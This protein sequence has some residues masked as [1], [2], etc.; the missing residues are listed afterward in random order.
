M[1][2]LLFTRYT[3]EHTRE[4]SRTAV[5]CAAKISA[6]CSI[7]NLMSAL[8]PTQNRSSASTVGDTLLSSHRYKLTSRRTVKSSIYDHTLDF[9]TS[10][11]F[12]HSAI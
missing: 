8:T 5:T 9:L 1:V 7:S 11:K 10:I 6:A 12:Q 2:P 3:C 4:K